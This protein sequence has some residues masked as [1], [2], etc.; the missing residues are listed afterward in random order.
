MDAMPRDELESRAIACARREHVAILMDVDG[1]L[2]PFADSLDE[3]VLDRA[4]SNLLDALVF[5]GVR[6][7]L[8][9]G[10]PLEHVEVLRSAVQGVWCSAEHGAWWR[11]DGSWEGPSPDAALDELESTLKRVELP[12]GVFIERKARGLCVHWRR[13]A[14]R[15]RELV[16]ETA[17]EMFAGWLR[18][19]DDYEQLHGR[20]NLELRHRSATKA[21]AVARVRE[22]CPAHHVISIGDDTTDEDMFAGMHARDL[23]IYV[24]NGRR[25]DTR[26]AAALPNPSAVRDFLWWLIETRSHGAR[27]RSPL[28]LA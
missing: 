9:S 21:N 7:V 16:I 25:R 23:A 12:P 19:R 28:E 17:H 24:R 8:V 11:D 22:L 14:W 10:R 13:V 26:A 2:I 20:H 27:R 5:A 3:A 6:I 15:D 18:S 1:T 4:G